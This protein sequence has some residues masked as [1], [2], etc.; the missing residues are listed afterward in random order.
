[1]YHTQEKR[2]E[3]LASG[4]LTINPDAWLGDG[5]Y[6]WYYEDD[7]TW[8]GITAKRN[9]GYYEVYKADI[10]CDNVLDTVFNEEHY[11]FWISKIEEA[12]KKFVK[13]K[14][15]LS[16]KYLN[17]FFKE[18]GAFTGVDGVMFQDISDNPDSWIIKKF[19]YKKRI[20]L[21]AYNPLII[22]NF[23]FDFEGKCV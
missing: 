16:L 22:S 15:N 19:Q 4:A 7:A 17:D 13:G 12:I 9:C 5:I 23:V 14:K 8:W 2:K 10:E 21:V 3:K 20:Q 11:N 18:K 6:F 1:M